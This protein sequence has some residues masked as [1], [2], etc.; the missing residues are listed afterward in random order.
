MFKTN[1]AFSSFSAPDLD[2]ERRFYR[3]MLGL[4]VVDGGMGTLELRTGSAKVMIYPKPD[5]EP[6]SFTVLNFPVDNVEA[7]VDRLSALGVKF[8]HY[9]GEIETDAK[10]IF[11][12]NGPTIAW[13]KDPAGNILSVLEAK[14]AEKR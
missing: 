11:R 5:H 3:D 9:E 2:V 7:E 8:E 10:G 4:D 6:A 12:G 13:F 1:S 14:Q